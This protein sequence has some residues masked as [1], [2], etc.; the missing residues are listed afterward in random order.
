MWFG[1][2]IPRLSRVCE[3]DELTLLPVARAVFH[4]SGDSS[5]KITAPRVSTW[6]T[7]ADGSE[8]ADIVMNLTRRR[9][10]MFIR[11]EEIQP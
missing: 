1:K 6:I 5:D 7:F 3:T 8:G 2:Y 10:L 4:T 9:P 11:E